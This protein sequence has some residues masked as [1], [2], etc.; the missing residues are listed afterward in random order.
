[1]GSSTGACR[2]V[3]GG[4]APAPA[5]DAMARVANALASTQSGVAGWGSSVDAAPFHMACGHPSSPLLGKM[6]AGGRC[7][8]ELASAGCVVMGRDRN[9]SDA[10]LRAVGVGFWLQILAA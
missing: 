7:K 5:I 8:G 1:M 2:A 3:P 10:R 4:I 9:R 6:L